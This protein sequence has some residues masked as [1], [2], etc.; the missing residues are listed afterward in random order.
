MDE[1]KLHTQEFQLKGI[2]RN[3]RCKLLPER[4][5]GKTTECSK[6]LR[7]TAIERGIFSELKD[8]FFKYLYII[9]S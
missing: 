3:M 1:K 6:Y 2:G 5:T 8:P 4:S 9:L 7:H